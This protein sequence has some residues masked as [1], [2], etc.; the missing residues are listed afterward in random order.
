MSKPIDLEEK[1]IEFFILKGFKTEDAKYFVQFKNAQ[2]LIDDGGNSLR[3]GYILLDEAYKEWDFIVSLLKDVEKEAIEQY[4]LKGY[5]FEVCRN[6]G[7][8]N[9]EPTFTPEEYSRA[10]RNGEI[11]RTTH[12]TCQRCRQ[13]VP[14]D[15]YNKYLNTSNN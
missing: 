4:L 2:E 7:K 5:S 10:Q 3:Y 8:H 12:M 13:S 6:G 9:F 1:K 11:A 14:V 15:L